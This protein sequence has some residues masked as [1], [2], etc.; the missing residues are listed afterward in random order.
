[1]NNSVSLGIMRHSFEEAHH[2]PDVRM[3]AVYARPRQPVCRP[4]SATSPQKPVHPSSVRTGVGGCGVSKGLTL[5]WHELG[6][7]LKIA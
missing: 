4:E 3:T 6:I 2:F 1:M 7:K 5:E